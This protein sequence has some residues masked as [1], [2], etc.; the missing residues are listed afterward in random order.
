MTK[1]R[2]ALAGAQAA[3][4]LRSTLCVAVRIQSCRPKE[5]ERREHLT[6]THFVTQAIAYSVYDRRPRDTLLRDEAVRV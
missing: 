6:V 5:S 1:A 3:L 2:A 4:R